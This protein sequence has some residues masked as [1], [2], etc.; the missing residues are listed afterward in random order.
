MF[1]LSGEADDKISE[2]ALPK[3]P[4]CPHHWSNL[5]FPLELDF[6]PSLLIQL[7]PTVAQ[8]I[9]EADLRLL[10]KTG[11][12]SNRPTTVLL[13]KTGKDPDQAP[14]QPVTDLSIAVHL[15]ASFAFMAFAILDL[16]PILDQTGS[17]QVLNERQGTRSAIH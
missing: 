11:P 14:G 2:V 5:V 17:K 1:A 13:Q 12:A 3:N 15:R 6:G 9:A 4:A 10:T 16:N 8:P 7:H